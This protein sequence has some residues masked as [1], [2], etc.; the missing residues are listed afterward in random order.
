MLDATGFGHPFWS[1]YYVAIIHLR[2]IEGCRPPYIAFPEATHEIQIV[3]MNPEAPL[4]DVDDWGKP[5][6]PVNWLLPLELEHQFVVRDDEQAELLGQLVVEAICR[7][8]SPDQDHRAYWS[9]VVDQ[10]AEHICY[11]TH[12][13]WN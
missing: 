4:S 5:E 12:P 13:T 9:V 8:N 6:Q 1:W 7:G 3:A 2:P 10:T 11:G